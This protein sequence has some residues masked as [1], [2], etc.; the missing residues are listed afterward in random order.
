MSKTTTI[1]EPD[2][3]E[4]EAG[5]AQPPQPYNESVVVLPGGRSLGYAEYGDPDGDPVLW[6]HGTPGAR[7]Q[8]PPDINEEAAARGFRVIPVERPGTGYSTPYTYEN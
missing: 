3:A 1:P 7:K 2:A 4:V 6:F 8:I 5:E